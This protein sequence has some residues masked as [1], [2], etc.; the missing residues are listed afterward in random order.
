MYFIFILGK[1]IILSRVGDNFQV[2]ELLNRIFSAK[3]LENKLNRERAAVL[4]TTVKLVKK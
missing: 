4:S 3:R 1:S 2:K